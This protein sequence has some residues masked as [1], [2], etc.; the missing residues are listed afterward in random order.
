MMVRME[1]LDDEEVW[2]ALGIL[3]VRMRIIHALST[4]P[5]STSSE[6]SQLLGLKG[7]Q[8]SWHLRQMEEHG[9]AI[10][11]DPPGK[12]RSGRTVYWHLD[13]NRLEEMLDI[14]AATLRGDR[15][16]GSSE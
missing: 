6:L 1:R 4:N 5:E 9:L 8:V 10:A 12:K 2:K 7:P 11:S 15:L 13:R 16:L 3:P 14:A